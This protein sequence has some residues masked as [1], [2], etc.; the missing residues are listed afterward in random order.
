VSI[1][2]IKLV[3]LPSFRLQLRRPILIPLEATSYITML[4]EWKF[5]MGYILVVKKHDIVISTCCTVTTL[6]RSRQNDEFA[7][8]V[9]GANE[10]KCGFP[11]CG[12]DVE[13]VGY[14]SHDI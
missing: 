1:C 7:L 2:G 5:G 10:R 9:D 14:V 3:K 11:F 4:V 13:V 6:F 8:L 12:S